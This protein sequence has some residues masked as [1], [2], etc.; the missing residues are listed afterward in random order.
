MEEVKNW[1]TIIGFIL[2]CIGTVVLVFRSFNDP[3]KKSEKNIAINN[4]TCI[5]KH[6][7]IDEVFTD[8]K[9]SIA[10]IDYTFSHF[11]ENEFRHIE[12]STN[13]VNVKMAGIDGKI[14]M[15]VNIVSKNQNNT[16]N[17]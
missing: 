11:K 16:I 13:A 10:G 5:Q 9:K 2:M 14:D 17:K 4:A 7:R 15:L 12:D 6:A 8:V 1:V 3:D